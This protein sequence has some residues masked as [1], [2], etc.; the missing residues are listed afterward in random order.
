[1]MSIFS[2]SAPEESYSRQLDKRV[3]GEEMVYGYD[4]SG[5]PAATSDYDEKAK[6]AS[7]GK[8]K[9]KGGY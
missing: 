1:M 3:E 8:K 5:P 4:G 9:S 2:N 6:E 7:Y